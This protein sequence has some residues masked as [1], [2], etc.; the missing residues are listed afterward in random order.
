MSISGYVAI[1][2]DISKTD[3]LRKSD[4]VVISESSNVDTCPVKL[5]RRYLSQVERFL[6]DS[7]HYV[8]RALSKTK[9][10]HT[11]ISVNKPISYSSIRDYFS[12]SFKDIV[13]DISLFSTHFV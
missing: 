12:A 10:G 3:Q 2:L 11:L 1:N 4:Q 7:T 5:L 6:V 9:S 13:P 8:F